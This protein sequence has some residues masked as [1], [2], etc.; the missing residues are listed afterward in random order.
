VLAP[1]GVAKADRVKCVARRP[2][3]KEHSRGR[4]RVGMTGDADDD[5]G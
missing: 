5:V 2:I 4:R 1:E 3:Q